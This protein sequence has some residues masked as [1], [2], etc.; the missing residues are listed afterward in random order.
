M[1]NSLELTLQFLCPLCRL[2]GM[3]IPQFLASMARVFR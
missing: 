1:S 2:I 3:E